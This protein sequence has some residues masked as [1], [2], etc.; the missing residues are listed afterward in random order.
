MVAGGAV[1]AAKIG[2]TIAIKYGSQRKQF[3]DGRYK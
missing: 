3:E 1:N 2:L